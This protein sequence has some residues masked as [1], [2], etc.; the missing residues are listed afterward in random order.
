[1]CLSVPAEP[2]ERKG[3]I[4]LQKGACL[5]ESSVALKQRPA[6]CVFRDDDRSGMQQVACRKRCEGRAV[7]L[8]IV[9]RRI[10]EDDVQRLAAQALQQR[11]GASALDLD[12]GGNAERAQV[13]A[14]GRERGLALLSEEDLGCTARDSLDADRARTGVKVGETCALHPRS[15]HVEERFPQPVAGRPCLCAARR[16]QRARA[17]RTGDH[18]HGRS[19]HAGRA[20]CPRRE[21]NRDKYNA[22]MGWSLNLGRWFGVELR[23]HTLFFL[24]MPGLMLLSTATNGYALRGLGLWMLLLGAVLVR[25][26]ARTLA[27]AVAGLAPPSRLLLLPMCA[28]PQQGEAGVTLSPLVERILA[29]VGPLANFFAGITLALLMYAATP[30]INLFERP[31]FAPAHLLRAA[32]WSQVL[33]GG[34]NLLPAL[35]LDAGLLLRNQLR[36]M[37]GNDVGTRSAAS[38]SQ[39]VSL[40]LIAL[41]FALSNGW[42]GLMGFLVLLAGRSESRTALAVAAT[43]AVTIGEVMLRE[44]AT[45]SASDTLEDALRG[46]VQSLQEVFPVVRGSLVVGSV[47]RDAM[48]MAMHSAGNSYVQ[49]AMNRSVE[50]VSPEDLLVPTLRRVQANRGVQLLQVVRGDQVVGIVAAGHLPQSMAVLGRTN[51][52]LRVGDRTGRRG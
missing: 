41:G 40:M 1:M 16:P 15:E 3:R 4:A 27:G 36:R 31:W 5:P 30:Y 22:G 13:G 34:L 50:T 28:V 43:E 24:L 35:P 47:S 7:S 10:E 9:I 11:G 45:V 21:E 12:A 49:S 37:R 17:K 26:I 2:V 52:A 19:I 14:D 33:L 38:I 48:L 20:E 42:V 51:R 18:T 44:F 46:S 23:L 6:L 39:V 32:I 29:L 25:E 8:C